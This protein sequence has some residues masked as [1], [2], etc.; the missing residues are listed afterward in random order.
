MVGYTFDFP[1]LDLLFAFLS[2][3][4]FPL[5]RP[6]LASEAKTVLT[7]LSFLKHILLTYFSYPLTSLLTD[8]VC[9][10]LC[11]SFRIF[12]YAQTISKPQN[13]SISDYL[14]LLT[15]I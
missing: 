6:L 3:E 2:T 15:A 5:S 14:Y 4:V 8:F 1:Y 11:F 12:N 10:T 7:E 13:C 9:L